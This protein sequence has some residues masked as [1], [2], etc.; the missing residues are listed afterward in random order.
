LRAAIVDDIARRHKS[1]DPVLSADVRLALLTAPRHLFAEG[2]LD[3]EG[4]YAD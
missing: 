3:L 4:A 1:L 2:D